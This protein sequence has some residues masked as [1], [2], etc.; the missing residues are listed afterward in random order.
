MSPSLAN[1]YWTDAN[2]PRDATCYVER[3]ADQDLYEAL[4]QGEF[5]Y[6]LT[7]RQMGKSSLM[8]RIAQRL[9]RD[10][11]RV[12]TIDLTAIGKKQSVKEWYEGMLAVTGR[13]LGLENELEAYWLANERLGLLQRWMGAL[14][15]V[16]LRKWAGPVVIF[17]DEVD[18]VLGLPFPVDEFF[19]GI[20][21]CH[22]ERTQDPELGRLTFCLLGVA[23]PSDLIQDWRTTPFNIGRRIELHDFTLAE[24]APLARGL[25]Q[26]GP[27]AERLLRRVLYWTGGQP[28]L[29][30]RLCQAVAKQGRA[31]RPADVDRNCRELFLRPMAWSHDDHLK[32][33]SNL[34][35]NSAGPRD[36]DRAAM[37]DLYEQV[38]R[39]RRVA[40]EKTN[41]LVDRLRLSGV[42]RVEAGHL[43]VRNPIYE[44]VFDRTWVVANLPGAE[45]RRQRRAFRRGVL[46][47]SAVAAALMAV[48]GG[49]GALGW[50]EHRDA[51]A[52]KY[53]NEVVTEER[54]M[55]TEALAEAQR[56][57]SE[58]ERARSEAEKAKR[59][60][61]EQRRRADGEADKARDR[62][63]RLAVSMGEDLQDQ[64]KLTRAL[65]WFADALKMDERDPVRGP[66]HRL[67]LAAALEQCPR[68]VRFWFAK[69]A[70]R[71]AEFS[72]DGRKILSVHGKDPGKA[73]VWDVGTGALL[74]T[75]ALPKDGD[76]PADPH[77]GPDGQ[78]LFAEVGKGGGVWNAVTGQS[79]PG[80]WE[81]STRDVSWFS[82]D[83]SRLWTRGPDEKVRIWDTQTGK[84][85]G[86]EIPR[87]E[88]AKFSRDGRWLLT[89]GAEAIGVWDTQTGKP[90]G[91]PWSRRDMR[92]DGEASNLEFS[93]DARLVVVIN[94]GGTARDGT[95]R[96]STARDGPERDSPARGGKARVWDVLEGR[97][98]GQCDTSGDRVTC[99]GFSKD[100]QYLLTVEEAE[101]P[102][103]LRG[104][105]GRISGGN[106]RIRV[107]H[108]ASGKLKHEVRHNGKINDIALSTD[109]R[110]LVT[111]CEDRSARLFDLESPRLG[112][113]DKPPPVVPFEHSAS[114][115]SA[116]FSPDGRY[117]ATACEDGT[118]QVWHTKTGEAITP[119]LVH[120]KPVVRTSF[121]ADGQ[122]V[123]TASADGAVRLWSLHT[124]SRV[125][126]LEEPARRT[127][128]AGCSEDGRRVLLV[129]NDGT[130]CVYDV[131]S[132]RRIP[133]PLPAD[134]WVLR[135]WLSPDGR[136]V[137]AFGKGNRVQI[138][139]VDGGKVVPL[140]GDY[141]EVEAC[142][143][144]PDGR[145][146]VTVTVTYRLDRSEERQAQLWDLET[147]MKMTD[148]ASGEVTA[149]AIGP[150]GEVAVASGKAV[151]LWG[152]PGSGPP[153]KL[154]GDSG[155]S[156]R[157]TALGLSGDGRRLV[158]GGAD[159]K[160][161]VWD[162]TS[163]L[164]VASFPH[165]GV[166]TCVGLNADGRFAV[167]GSEDKTVQIWEVDKK[168]ART[169]EPL[170]HGETVHKAVFDASE[171]FAVTSSA[172]GMVRLWDART[173]RPVT[174][175]LRH[176]VAVEDARL[177]V[178]AT[179]LVVVRADH[180]VEVWDLGRVLAAKEELQRQV[181]LHSAT[182][183]ADQGERLV[184]IAPERLQALWAR[185]R[186]VPLSGENL[187]WH[188]QEAGKCEA[189]E[190]WDAALRHLKPL[191]D[192]Q[193]SSVL[194]AHLGDICLKRGK[195]DEALNAY[196]RAARGSDP[197]PVLPWAE[198]RAYL[199]L[200]N[201]SFRA[202]LLARSTALSV[203]AFVPQESALLASVT[204][205]AS[206]SDGP[207]RS[208]SWYRECE[209]RLSKLPEAHPL[210]AEVQQELLRSYIGVAEAFVGGGEILLARQTFQKCH[211]LLSS[212]E[213]GPS[214]PSLTLKEV[215]RVA[216]SWREFGDQRRN[217]RDLESAR[218]TY[219][220]CL[221]LWNMAV[222]GGIPEDD[223]DRLELALVLERL[224][225][226]SSRSDRRTLT[227][228]LRELALA[229]ARVRA[230]PTSDNARGNLHIVLG[231][232][233]ALELEL[234]SLREAEKHYRKRLENDRQWVKSD[235]KNSRAKENLGYSYRS[236]A[237]VARTRGDTGSAREYEK[238]ALDLRQKLATDSPADIDAQ[239]DL[240]R[241]Y[242]S[243][244]LFK[245]SA[246]CWRKV[247]ELS[248]ADL[249]GKPSNSRA[250]K[251]RAE[252]LEWLGDLELT[253]GNPR[254]AYDYCRRCVDGK[255]A[256]VDAA[257]ADSAMKRSL[258]FAYLWVGRTGLPAGE[259]E[260]TQDALEKCL[261]LRTELARSDPNDA[262]EDLLI[263][264]HEELG[265][266]WR[267]V[268][269]VGKAES[270]Y[271]T[272]LDRRLKREMAAPEDPSRRRALA[273]AH[274][275]I[276][277][278][279][280]ERN[281]IGAARSS[282]R[283]ALGIA[284][285]LAR[286]SPG[287][288]QQQTDLAADY[289]YMG[290]AELRAEDFPEAAKW[291]QQAVE[292]YRKLEAE[293]KLIDPEDQKKS[294]N[295]RRRLSACKSAKQAM[296]DLE[297]ARKQ[298]TR[299]A[300]ADLLLL[301]AAALARRGEHEAAL[302][303]AEALRGLAP[304]EADNRYDLARCYAL[305]LR[306][307]AKGQLSSVEQTLHRTCASRAVG[308]LAGAMAAGFR[309]RPRFVKD[310][311]LHIIRQE[312][313]YRE[314]VVRLESPPRS[315]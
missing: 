189:E 31:G 308:A 278:T 298:P 223:D 92:G 120:S 95:A 44:R 118:A 268:G 190:N 248:Q 280:L 276:G 222:K 236:M 52:A 240:A 53:K 155:H 286:E 19:A 86:S 94:R 226:L 81:D 98:L 112:E 113:E 177:G 72:P 193:P 154:E 20:R 87:C 219:Q 237:T 60:E 108:I 139:D 27:A 36:E 67:R 306:S 174:P 295:L 109:G 5:C 282:F 77:F 14:R 4:H 85:V 175:P 106:P 9:R 26:S 38:R 186:A 64:G 91:K 25:N 99:A 121:S 101:S 211:D 227:Y 313:A 140:K 179:R 42:V 232:L 265:A 107:Y 132:A 288:L 294:K 168:G 145:Y 261:A 238:R 82:P 173:G 169:A 6:V 136:R 203:S 204:V 137:A 160:A 247:L 262:N 61:E 119:P 150:A 84:Q 245:E 69:E 287:L 234:G 217:A 277:L 166:L 199:A 23:S 231:R 50:M 34:V 310:D 24:A 300:A 181:R 210:T 37:L 253:L 158:S 275:S 62:A 187:A 63:A 43:R 90:V 312:P 273:S 207:P 218:P 134:D 165:G 55:A 8:V 65:V 242:Y 220:A 305:V 228:Y 100:N 255:K 59:G 254:A 33:I 274:N 283:K 224:G 78:W 206:R 198:A 197:P 260:Q 41:Q 200:G 39:G 284:L 114:V 259:V 159:R 124:G 244:D 212:L 297:F 40:Y 205:V 10:G 290:D 74:T 142:A 104:R 149:V 79:R 3:Q 293:K 75:V 235:P 239:E 105:Y 2:L 182:D 188:W 126:A 141:S 279:C 54:D 157:V 88:G 46:R 271:G 57:R 291:F 147:G 47:G 138:W 30:Q 83:G 111:S 89:V 250:L 304:E 258:T 11:A 269:D 49:L 135:A 68:P 314:L 208:F 229:E 164:L 93:R 18:S 257:P 122:L 309:D 45:K 196:G 35:L 110:W 161:L 246:E 292:V 251:K 96:D 152:K 131:A 270:H 151:L 303:T 76:G 125:L 66:A 296:A 289:A 123:L 15:D 192:H 172:D 117:L 153:R 17:V 56:A 221:A 58:A 97:V 22:N 249:E 80:P 162:V 272:A 156:D 285:A 48:M 143:F 195:I 209:Q 28:Y 201:A 32:F 130:A 243:L 215:S 176:S 264:A 1:F 216:K 16:V 256:L 267:R 103:H 302:A 12:V 191:A 115:Q 102:G 301:R 7:S 194:L 144:G 148:L 171:C 230:S 281:D 129:R 163:G 51:L 170:Q 299:E 263:A 214:V 13:Q 180:R 266:F 70:V 311:D 29:T 233:G 315:K 146:L 167:T 307:I 225:D 183:L 241:T 178:D 252:A 185:E 213:A 127:R 133:L 184:T 128:Q 73:R 71:Y 21:A 116:A 202:W